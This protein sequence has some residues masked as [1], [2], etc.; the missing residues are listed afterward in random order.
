MLT[1]ANRD[2]IHATIPHIASLLVG[3]AAEAIEDADIVILTAN[4]PEYV[5]PARHLG[6]ERVLL[7]FAHV[8][9]LKQCAN[10]HGVNW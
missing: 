8:P 3:S 6:D 1:G 7:D 9:A 5:E 4:V 10:Y 2:Y